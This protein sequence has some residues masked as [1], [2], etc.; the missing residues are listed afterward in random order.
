MKKNRF[1]ILFFIVILIFSAFPLYAGDGAPSGH[2]P[3]EIEAY[4]KCLDRV[5]SDFNTEVG[6]GV[7]ASVVTTLVASPAGGVATIT[8]FVGDA[9]NT[10][11]QG[12]KDCKEKYNMN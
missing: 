8:Y 4:N 3:E 6:I 7:V 1:I 2:T 12:I 10:A 5:Q 9:T 11:S